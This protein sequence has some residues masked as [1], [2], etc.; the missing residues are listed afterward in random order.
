M[1]CPDC[2][3]SCTEPWYVTTLYCRG[4]TARVVSRGID[5]DRVRKNNKVDA[6][7]R[8]VLE[9]CGLTHKEVRAA[10]D[11]DYVNKAPS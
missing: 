10:W 4:C 7:Y 6:A 2:T 8:D 3:K 5:F 9:R 1:T 11:A